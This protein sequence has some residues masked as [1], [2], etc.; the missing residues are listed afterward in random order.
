MTTG[1]GT[2]GDGALG[3]E[4]RPQPEGR[5]ARATLEEKLM[6]A[7]AEDTPVGAEHAPIHAELPPTAIG[8]V[9]GTAGASGGSDEGA[10]LPAGQLAN[11]AS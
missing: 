5:S 9:G 6:R 7:G 3:A 2:L 11:Q 4:L 1:P 10:G 8:S